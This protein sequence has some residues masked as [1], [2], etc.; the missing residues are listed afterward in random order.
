MFLGLLCFGDGLLLSRCTLL[1]A[2]GGGNGAAQTADG[3]YEHQKYRDKT[4]YEQSDGHQ[5]EFYHYVRR[6][7]CD[8]GFAAGLAMAVVV[9]IFHNI[10]GSKELHQQ[11]RAE[12]YAGQPEADFADPTQNLVACTCAG[13]LVAVGIARP[14]IEGNQDLR[15]MMNPTFEPALELAD[16]TLSL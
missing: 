8:V 7:A 16:S 15:K 6:G 12:E 5:D 10:I 2:E 11:A 3:L 4:E 13:Q 1:A 9:Y 14:D